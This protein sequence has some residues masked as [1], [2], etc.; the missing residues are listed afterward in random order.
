MLVLHSQ[1]KYGDTVGIQKKDM[2]GFG[3]VY[4]RG[5]E[6]GHLKTGHHKPGF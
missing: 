2:S 1:H 6:E 4:Y 5:F 3:M